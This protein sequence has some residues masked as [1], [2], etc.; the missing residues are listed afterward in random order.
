MLNDQVWREQLIS[1]LSTNLPTIRSKIKISQSSLAEAVGI[2]RQ[3][4]IS[5]ENGSNKMRWDTFLALML[6]LSKDPDAASLMDLLEL[7]I[8]DICFIIGE[9]MY[10][11]KKTSPV[12]QD[13]MWTDVEGHENAV[14]RG[15]A[16]LPA[17]LVNTKCPKCGSTNLKGVLITE[18]AD[19]EDPNII[20]TDCGYWRD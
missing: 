11:R 12:L 14:I 19:A 4:L 8:D 16:P 2:G 10:N 13:K 5:I 17:G 7:K 1:K 6:I 15:F 20:C 18:T 3:T 9:D